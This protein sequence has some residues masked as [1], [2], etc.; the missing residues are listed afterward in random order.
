M[1]EKYYDLCRYVYRNRPEETL[2]VAKAVLWRS[3]TFLVIVSVIHWNR[4]QVGMNGLGPQPHMV[5]AIHFFPFQSSNLL[6]ACLFLF[7][8]LPRCLVGVD[9]LCACPLC[10]VIVL[11]RASCFCRAKEGGP[12][13]DFGWWMTKMLVDF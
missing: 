5:V 7:F 3:S 8:S 1:E 12:P 9:A 10:E 6:Q 13:R 2:K 11:F 4:E